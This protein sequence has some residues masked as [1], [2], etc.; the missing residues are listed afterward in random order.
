MGKV[1]ERGL[2]G[3]LERV[4][5]LHRRAATPGE[6]AAAARARD[7]LVDHLTRLRQADPVARFVEEHLAELG[8]PGEPPPPPRSV[9]EVDDVL[10]VLAAWVAGAR[11]ADEVAAWAAELV[12]R[13]DFPADPEAPGAM[14]GEVLLQLS[15]DEHP[16]AALAPAAAAFLRTGDWAAWF[17]VVARETSR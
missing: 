13:V 3:R 14:V 4:E 8:V 12:D 10:G 5:A 7:R 9:P 2:R 16:P 11:A 1:D 17:A 15:S 6:R